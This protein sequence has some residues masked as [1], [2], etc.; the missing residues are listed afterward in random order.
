MISVAARRR[1]Q[2]PHYDYASPR[3]YFLTICTYG[4]ACLFG[5][6]A[7]G[8]MCLSAFGRIVEACWGERPAHYANAAF[9]SFVVMPN[10]LHG[11]LVLE[12]TSCPAHDFTEIVRGLKTFSARRVNE[13][14]A[15]PGKPLWQREYYEHV[16]RNE[17]ALRKIRRYIE[18]NPAGWDRDGDNPANI[19]T[20]AGLKPAPE[21]P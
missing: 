15:S 10:H 18:A 16:I 11:V 5:H 9:D 14:R 3:T 2:L 19:R 6:I 13:M 21:W 4:R 7:N 1:L 20:G 17:T 8:T 12:E